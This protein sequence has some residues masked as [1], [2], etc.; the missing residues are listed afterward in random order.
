[1][2]M[3]GFVKKLVK[4]PG[5]RRKQFSFSQEVKT[6]SSDAADEGSKAGTSEHNDRQLLG[7]KG[8][9]R[10]PIS[11][12]GSTNSVLSSRSSLSEDCGCLVDRKIMSKLG[13]SKYVK[14]KHATELFS[15]WTAI[16]TA[17]W[18]QT[19]GL[20]F[21]VD[22]VLENDLH[23]ETLLYFDE[24]AL[25]R[26]SGRYLDSGIGSVQMALGIRSL[27]VS[28]YSQRWRE[29]WELK[30]RK[31]LST[32]V[33]C[34]SRASQS[35][36]TNGIEKDLSS[37]SLTEH[38]AIA[39]NETLNP[40]DWGVEETCQWLHKIGL[41]DHELLFRNMGIHMVLLL[42]SKPTFLEGLSV[43]VVTDL[44]R[45]ER[46]HG[47]ANDAHETDTAT[48][49]SNLN[50]AEDT[51]A[52]SVSSGLEANQKINFEALR[53]QA[54]DVQESRLRTR[55]LLEDALSEVWDGLNDLERLILVSMTGNEWYSKAPSVD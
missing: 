21:L 8:T 48:D 15:D 55:T 53:Q 17:C 19:M 5:L 14:V 43:S 42:A 18:L 20:G 28:L 38:H 30:E 27:L 31:P 6:D 47:Q 12:G 22:Q 36:S 7:S 24:V 40:L 11:T 26:L 46:R 16:T 3:K 13:V 54:K 41:G 37:M 2:G 49:T 1:M 45:M 9:L 10:V 4:S 32:P 44:P 39:E 33:E 23:M 51:P 35:S 34:R 50:V 52:Q 29:Q 25:S